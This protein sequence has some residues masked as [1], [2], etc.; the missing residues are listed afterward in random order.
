MGIET[1]GFSIV[2]QGAAES[3]TEVRRVAMDQPWPF[4]T[5]FPASG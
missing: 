4:L 2:T 1:D 5:I 3:L